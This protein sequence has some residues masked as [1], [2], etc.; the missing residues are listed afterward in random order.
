MWRKRPAAQR[1]LSLLDG[2]C[3]YTNT[4]C[5]RALLP[6]VGKYAPLF[7]HRLSGGAPAVR[8]RAMKSRW[9]VCWPD[10]GQIT[11]NRWLLAMPEEAREYVVVHELVHLEHPDHGPGFYGAL[12]AI[13]P[14]YKERRALL[15]RLPGKEE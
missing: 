11:L 8:Y 15:A 1:P 6:Y 4:D 9:G 10:R 12:A 13:L 5:D 14:D 7:A 2:P 3:P